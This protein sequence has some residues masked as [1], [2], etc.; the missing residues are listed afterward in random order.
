VL[1]AGR[2]RTINISSNGILIETEQALPLRTRI[3]LSI[4]WP[5]RLN[6][7]TP[8]QLYIQ[9]KTVRAEGCRTAAR[10]LRHEFRTRPGVQAIRPEA[11]HSRDAVNVSQLQT[12]LN[13]CFEDVSKMAVGGIGDETRAVL[14][15]I[16]NEYRAKLDRLALTLPL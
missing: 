11:V 14:R 4:S 16:V 9:A 6:N 5:A 10:I 15:T 8:L 1:R 3:D 2:G 7:V 13:A 12:R